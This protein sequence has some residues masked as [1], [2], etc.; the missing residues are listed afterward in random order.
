V[1][2]VDDELRGYYDASYP[3]SLW[4]PVAPP[5]TGATAGIPGTWIP[6]GS[7]PPATVA[8]LIAG[9]PNPVTASPATAWTAGQYVQTA[10]AGAAG[11]ANWSGIA[12]VA[13][14]HAAA[15]DAEPEPD[16]DEY[17]A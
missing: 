14:P 15:A 8:N 13:G 9:V 6:A 4:A 16:D 1:S 11:Q 5:A 10:A 2:D 7:T 3:P 12:W 17:Q